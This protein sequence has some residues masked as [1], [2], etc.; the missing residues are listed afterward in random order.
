MWVLLATWIVG[1]DGI[2]LAKGE[3]WKTVLEVSLG[4][5]QVVD[6]DSPL[7]FELI[8]DPLAVAGPTYGI[9]AKVLREETSGSFLDA[10]GVTLTPSALVRWPSGTVLA[11]KS[12]LRGGWYPMIPPPEHLI[13]DGEVRQLFIREWDAVLDGAPNSYRLQP[14]TLR[15]RSI[16]RMETWETSG[17]LDGPDKVISDYLLEL[18]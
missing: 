15:V 18:T 12:E 5:A 3:R 14:E 13:F 6:S 16:Q 11:F 1:D 10:G 7:R 9:V 17:G 4:D 8:G 2:E